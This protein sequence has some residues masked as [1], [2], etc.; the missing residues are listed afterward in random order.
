[1]SRGDDPGEAAAPI[2][3]DQMEA[4]AAM[5]CCGDDVECVAHQ[6]VDMVGI[7][8]LRIGTSAGRIASLVGG[9]REIARVG[10]CGNLAVPEMPRY[11]EAVEKQDRQPVRRARQRAVE[12]QARRRLDLADVHSRFLLA[13]ATA[14]ADSRQLVSSIVPD[15]VFSERGANSGQRGQECRCPR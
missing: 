13:S 7:E 15:M 8:I 12:F 1:M 14:Y 10:Q 4:A 6:A 11:A 5:P 2:V 3:A 9:D